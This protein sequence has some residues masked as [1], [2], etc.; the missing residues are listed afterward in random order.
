MIKYAR[1]SF[2]IYYLSNFFIYWRNLT[3]FLGRYN[4]IITTVLYKIMIFIKAKEVLYT[5]ESFYPRYV[6]S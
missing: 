3:G 1:I 4:V 6:S 2:K 5:F